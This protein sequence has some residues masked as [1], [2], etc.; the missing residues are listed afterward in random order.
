M[1]LTV[2][3]KSSFAR[4][5]ITGFAIH[6]SLSCSISS[7]SRSSSSNTL[8]SSRPSPRS[9]C[10]IPASRRAAVS[11]G[12]VRGEGSRQKP[13]FPCRTRANFRSA[14][15][16]HRPV[17][18]TVQFEGPC[19]RLG[20]GSARLQVYASRVP[21]LRSASGQPP[22]PPT[23]SGSNLRLFYQHP[24]SCT[25]KRRSRSELAA[26]AGWC[27]SPTTP[28]HCP[29]LMQSL[30]DLMATGPIPLHL[31]ELCGPS[32]ALPK[33]GHGSICRPPG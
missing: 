20:N 22:Q 17:D 27:R 29:I 1:N 23:S 25:S 24:T 15:K 11:H 2:V 32:Q 13:D 21:L 10:A 31:N 3:R 18:V 33:N 9:S 26:V 14:G 7:I 30:H 8:S 16:Q 19:R 4:G 5:A 12:S 6:S 28:P